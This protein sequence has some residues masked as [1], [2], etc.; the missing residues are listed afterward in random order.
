[1][2]GI[3]G[4]VADGAPSLQSLEE[5]LAAMRHRGP[6]DQ[7][8]W[9]SGDTGLAHARL[10]IIDRAHGAQPMR[11]RDGRYAVVFNGEIYNHRALR[12]ELERDGER[13]DTGCDTEVLLPMFVRHGPAMVDRLQGMFALAVVDLHAERVFL[14]RDRF[15]KKPLYWAPSGAGVAFG[16]TL[17]ALLPLL[18]VRP[19]IDPDAIARY[20]VLQY[21]PGAMTPWCGV[22]KVEPGSWVDWREGAAEQHRYWSPPLPSPTRAA[23]DDPRSVH[24]ELRSRIRAAVLARLESEVP[25]GVFLSGGIDS[26]VVVAEMSAAGVRPSTYSVGFTHGA[27]DETPWAVMVAEALGTDHRVL[28]LDADAVTMLDDL[29]WAYDEPF[30]DSS[31]LATLAVSRAAKDHVTVALTGDGGDELFGGYERY[32]AAMIGAAVGARLGAVT[33]PVAASVR[34]LARAASVERIEALTRFIDDPWHAARARVTHF[35]PR[36]ALALLRPELRPAADPAAAERWLD[37]RWIASGSDPASI[38][39]VDAHTYLPDDL[40]TKMDRATM[41]WGVEARSPLL[42][43]ELWDWVAG[44]PRPWLLDRR[45][46]KRL[47]REAYRGVLPDPILRRSKKGFSV[48]LTAWLRTHLRPA[49]LD[50]VRAADGPLSDLMDPAAVSSVVDAFFAGDDSLTY[51]TWNLLALATWRAARSDGNP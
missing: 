44:L 2:C 18:A 3:A 13:F 15:G 38:P 4:I 33:S 12:R 10:A 25:L 47:V 19:G 35:S 9:C 29:A 39:W 27:Y 51:R 40:L 22:H 26:S 5:S 8:V 34:T 49:V 1:M 32:R 37:D 11:S 24:A 30:A 14:A 46:G 7:D 31:A 20:L 43:H 28:A 21:V 42:D 23:T 16:S 48:P 17:D 36:E 6:D 45:A 41:A 50:R